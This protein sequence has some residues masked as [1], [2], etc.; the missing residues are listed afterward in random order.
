MKTARIENMIKG[1]VVGNF[2]PSLIRTSA[3]EVA[4][5]EYKRGDY[6][7]Q[8][9]HK[10]STEITV[11]SV[12]KVRMNDVE[13]TVGDII[14]IEPYEATDFEVLEDTITTVV[15]YPGAVN[16]KFLGQP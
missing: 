12:G 14:L 8:H 3:V 10:L 15:K 1:W 2:E 13:Y 16:D 4:V 9:Y 5:K 7:P 6:E 11:I